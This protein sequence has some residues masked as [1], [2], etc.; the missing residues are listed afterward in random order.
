VHEIWI[1]HEGF[2]RGDVLNA[3]AAPQSAC[4]PECFEAAFG[5]NPGTRQDDNR[6][7]FYQ[8]IRNGHLGKFQYY[9]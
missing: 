9:Q 3:V 1:A 5:G 7:I 4:T 2:G 8:A 6:A